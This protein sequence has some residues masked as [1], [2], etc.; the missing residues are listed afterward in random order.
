MHKKWKS[1][2]IHN[3]FTNRM[4]SIL[5]T[6]YDPRVKDTLD[7]LYNRG[8][9]FVIE[10]NDDGRHIPILERNE[11]FILKYKYLRIISPEKKETASVRMQMLAGNP[12]KIRWLN[13][14]CF[15]RRPDGNLESFKTYIEVRYNVRFAS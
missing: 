12:N 9:T 8:Y 4:S 5:I 2:A 10:H 1:F 6:T 11:K 3:Q 15:K 7:E 13:H 14:L